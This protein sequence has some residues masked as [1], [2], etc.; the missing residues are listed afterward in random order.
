MSFLTKV[1]TSFENKETNIM[2][3]NKHASKFKG[4]KYNHSMS[5]QLQSQ[6]LNHEH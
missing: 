4:Y 2:Y 1:A 3:P 5:H 6:T